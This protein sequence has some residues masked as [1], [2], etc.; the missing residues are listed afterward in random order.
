MAKN[1][2]STSTADVATAAKT[3]PDWLED[4][5]EVQTPVASVAAPVASPVAPV[6]PNVEPTGMVRLLSLREGSIGTPHGELHCKK[7]LVVP[8][9]FGE[10][11]VKQFP[12]HVSIIE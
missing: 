2:R 1:L 8:R 5:K 11:M 6:A 9:A 12:G 3:E 7:T 10:E 4:G